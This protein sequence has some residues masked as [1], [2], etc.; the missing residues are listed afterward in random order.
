MLGNFSFGDY[1]K[2]E[3][4]RYAWEFIIGELDLPVE[5]IHVSVFNGEGGIAPADDEARALWSALGVAKDHV[6]AF[7]R[8]DNFWGPAGCT[9]ACGPSSEIY[10]DL[11]PEACT[12]GGKCSPGADC[13]RYM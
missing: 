7:G 8:A 10:Y 9:G 13:P 5:R 1:F 4:I 11:G 6:I 3:A 12:C 2:T